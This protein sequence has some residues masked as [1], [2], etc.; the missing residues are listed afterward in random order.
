MSNNLISLSGSPERLFCGIKTMS[1]SIAVYGKGGIGKSTVVSH[2]AVAFSRRG[3]RVLQIGCD[4]KHDSTYSLVG[5]I[6]STVS[7]VLLKHNYHTD[8]IT[9][10]EIIFTGYAGVR[11]IEIGGPPAGVGCG[12][13]VIGEGIQLISALNIRQDFDIVLFD[14]LG[15]VVCGGFSIPLQHARHAVIVATD[16]FDSIYAA[17]R[18]VAAVKDKSEMYPVRLL[19]IIANKCSTTS[20]ID[21]FTKDVNTVVLSVIGDSERVKN[22]RVSGKTLYEVEELQGVDSSA[23]LTGPFEKIIDHFLN[24]CREQNGQ[25]RSLTDRE[26]FLNYMGDACITTPGSSER[27]DNTAH[28]A[29]S[30]V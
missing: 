4:P 27:T 28:S 12:G 10:E 8:D 18:V 22:A 20:R 2:M 5:K 11:V 29:H 23:S 24:P 30:A 26:M 21:R 25:I 14:V 3:R 13:Y 1:E 6:I 15:D 7:E 17:N 9:P 16:D 19:G